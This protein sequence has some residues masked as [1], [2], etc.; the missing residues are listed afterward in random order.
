VSGATCETLKRLDRCPARAELAALRAENAAQA[1]QIETLSR[2]RD[3]ALAHDTQP[4]PTAEAYE[5]VCAA[6]HQREAEI[7]TMRATLESTGEIP[8]KAYADD[9]VQ[10]ATTLARKISEALSSLPP[11]DMR[12]VPVERLREIECACGR[13]YDWCLACKAERPFRSDPGDWHKPDCWLAAAI[14]GAE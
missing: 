7:A 10:T 2:E 9:P 12:L 3:L 4:Y 11:S 5:L 13:E 8:L 6:L 14:K 1:K